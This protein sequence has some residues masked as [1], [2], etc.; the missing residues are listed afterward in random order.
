[1]ISRYFSA[2]HTNW[3]LKIKLVVVLYFLSFEKVTF[4]TNS[5]RVGIQ[6]NQALIKASNSRQI[7]KDEGKNRVAK[8]VSVDSFKVLVWG[9]K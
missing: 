7:Y 5:C 3:W 1:M 9:K 8:D 2:L 4:C 6:M